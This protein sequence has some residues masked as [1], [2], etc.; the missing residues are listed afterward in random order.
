M[1]LSRAGPWK[2]AAGVSRFFRGVASQT[3]P[4]GRRDFPCRGRAISVAWDGQIFDRRWGHF[5]EFRL[6]WMRP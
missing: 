1:E 3:R 6:F 5:G 2:G 4:C